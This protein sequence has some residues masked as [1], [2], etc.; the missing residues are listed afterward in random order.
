LPLLV[1]EHFHLS[2]RLESFFET[3]LSRLNS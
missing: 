3:R 1:Q 2:E